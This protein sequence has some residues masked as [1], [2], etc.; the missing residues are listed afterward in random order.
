MNRRFILRRIGGGVINT[1]PY[2]GKDTPR[3]QA[4]REAL[5]ALDAWLSAPIWGGAKLELV[6]VRQ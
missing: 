4:H 3:D 1:F 5:R 6:E 2:G